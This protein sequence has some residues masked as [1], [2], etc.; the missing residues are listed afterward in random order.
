LYAQP[1]QTDQNGFFVLELNQNIEIG[2]RYSL[3]GISNPQLSLTKPDGS[4]NY[5][6][7]ADAIDCFYF[8]PNPSTSLLSCPGAP[9]QRMALSQRGYVCTKSDDVRL[10]DAPF[11]SA[12]TINYLPVGSQFT[13][14]DGPS[15]ADNW[16]WW[17]I[18]T[19]YGVT[20]WIAEGGDQVDPYFICPMP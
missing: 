17:Q 19:D 8:D 4:F 13:V 2:Q 16:S 15:C 11:R 9:P 6:V 10:R 5:D 18:R 20:G 3:L 14:L 1:V 7:V 12:N